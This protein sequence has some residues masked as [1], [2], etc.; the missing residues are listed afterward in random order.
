LLFFRVIHLNGPRDAFEPLPAGGRP[1]R[2]L[3]AF[4]LKCRS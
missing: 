4:G 2:I 3:W 1:R